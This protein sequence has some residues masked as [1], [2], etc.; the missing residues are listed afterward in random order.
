MSYTNPMPNV[1]VYLYKAG[2]NI[3]EKGK[4]A[5]KSDE[6][7]IEGAYV[8]ENVPVGSYQI[9]A[10]Y[11]DNKSKFQVEPAVINATVDNTPVVLEPFHVIGLSIFGKVA[12][13][14]GKGIGGVKILIDGQQR[15]ISSEKG[16]YKLDEI[17]PGNYIL[18]G[19]SQHYIFDAMNI[20]IT[21]GSG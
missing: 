13:S 16:T 4:N 7:D 14:K 5:W 2:T 17:T 3:V 11:S 10:L 12:N 19:V 6:S 1:N 21:A 18:E 9:V 8:F 15:A 20:V